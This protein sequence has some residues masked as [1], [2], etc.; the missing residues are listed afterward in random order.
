MFKPKAKNHKNTI[1][2][3]IKNN[4]KPI[5]SSVQLKVFYQEILN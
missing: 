5:M 1:I 3:C 2:D 4:Q